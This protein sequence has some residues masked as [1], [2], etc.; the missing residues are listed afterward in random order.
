MKK[1]DMPKNLE[2]AWW[3]SHKPSKGVTEDPKFKSRL[4]FLRVHHIAYPKYDLNSKD[5]KIM[6]D[7]VNMLRQM[8][9]GI[10]ETKVAIDNMYKTCTNEYTKV[11]LVGYLELLRAAERDRQNWI[12]LERG[13]GN[14]VNL[15]TLLENP[16]LDDLIRI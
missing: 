1:G 14:T 4:E 2:Y 15:K 10:K 13:V 9:A 3:T 5:A 6:A 7:R 12:K 8:V 11:A 16:G